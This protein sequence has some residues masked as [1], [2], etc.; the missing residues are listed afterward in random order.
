FALGFVVDPRLLRQASKLV[1][2]YIHKSIQSP[3]LR[4]A[5]T[6]SYTMGCKRV[7][8]S[9]DYYPALQRENVALV[10][11]GIHEMRAGSIATRDGQEHAVDAVVLATGFQ[12]AEAVAPFPIRG[13]GGLDLAEAWRD[14]AEAYLGA[15]VAGFP[16]LFLV[17]GP[18]T[19]L[20]HS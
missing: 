9:N 15:T 18:N 12:A 17:V 1:L 8:L 11:E 14:G 10:T 7:L 4:A 6:P 20:G 3:A 13:R 19:G 5:V 2:A 16:N